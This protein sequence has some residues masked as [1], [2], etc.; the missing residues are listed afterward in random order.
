MARAEIVENIGGGYYRIRLIK[1]LKLIAERLSTLESKSSELALRIEGGGTEEEMRQLRSD[2][3]NTNSMIKVLKKA[4]APG[5]PILCASADENATI[6]VGTVVTVI[7]HACSGNASTFVIAPNAT[8]FDSKQHSEIVTTPEMSKWEWL[9]ARIA[10]PLA[11]TQKPKFWFGKILSISEDLRSAN[12]SIFPR[13]VELKPLL[14]KA[15]EEHICNCR[16][17]LGNDFAR[18]SVGDVVAVDFHFGVGTPTVIGFSEMPESPEFINPVIPTSQGFELELF[19]SGGSNKNKQAYGAV[20]NGQLRYWRTENSHVSEEIGHKLDTIQQIGTNYPI[21]FNLELRSAFL[22]DSARNYVQPPVIPSGLDPD[23][24]SNWKIPDTGMPYEIGKHAS[25]PYVTHDLRLVERFCRFGSEVDP[26]IEDDW[27]TEFEF[28]DPLQSVDSRSKDSVVEYEDLKPHEFPFYVKSLERPIAFPTCILLDDQEN[29]SAIRFYDP[30]SFALLMHRP[31]QLEYEDGNAIYTAGC[32]PFSCAH[33]KRPIYSGSY[34][35]IL[36]WGMQ[37]HFVITNENHIAGIYYPPWESPSDSRSSS[38]DDNPISQNG[39]VLADRLWRWD[40][41]TV[42]TVI[43]ED[44]AYN[45]LP[46]ETDAINLMSKDTGSVQFPILTVPV[47]T[48]YYDKWGGVY[49]PDFPLKNVYPGKIFGTES[50]ILTVRNE[51]TEEIEDRVDIPQMGTLFNK[52]GDYRTKRRDPET[53]EFRYTSDDENHVYFSE[54]RISF[55]FH[56][57]GT[58]HKPVTH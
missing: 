36:R 50:G 2:L 44:Y 14:P 6:P 32:N 41:S 15:T 40:Y 27:R 29:P 7:E 51:V 24:F 25:M 34:E 16:Y 57:I 55:R 1:K 49:I 53:G 31:L 23:D 26:T 33:G 20:F 30:E 17:R 4:S 47:D 45:V 28:G 22:D 42:D 19:L 46:A 9:Y 54:N 5:Q 35:E 12:V 43:G 52:L 3:I 58:L 13:T 11:I 56:F 21:E 10:Q 37:E 38:R 39:R 18:F 48:S 8:N